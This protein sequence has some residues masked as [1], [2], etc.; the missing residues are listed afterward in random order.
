M[1][2]Q[3]QE[4][5]RKPRPRVRVCVNVNCAERG[6]QGVCDAL[7]QSPELRDTDIATTPDCFRFC[8]QG[9]NVAVNG[10]VLH[11]MRPSDAVRRVKKEI[12]YPS[13][14][15]NGA[16]TRSI[17]DLDDVLDNLL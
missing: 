8:K 1:Y 6:S 10:N 7:K 9:P 2:D 4:A 15:L 14:K 16:G 17:D 3:K 13:R 5:E 11:D 12:A